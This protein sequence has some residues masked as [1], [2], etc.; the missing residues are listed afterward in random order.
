MKK[1]ILIIVI[2]ILIAISAFADNTTIEQ[3]R[4]WM[5]D[6]YEFGKDGNNCNDILYNYGT[7]NWTFSSDDP[8]LLGL[9]VNA[10]KAGISDKETGQNSLPGLLNKLDK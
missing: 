4:F 1:T 9:L 2:F 3:N 6:S 10:C 8:D 5:T 7:P